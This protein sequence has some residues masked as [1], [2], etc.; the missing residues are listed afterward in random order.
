MTGLEPLQLACTQLGCCRIPTTSAAAHLGVPQVRLVVQPCPCL[1]TVPSSLQKQRV[2]GIAQAGLVGVTH[3]WL[4]P[5]VRLLLRAERTCSLGPSP[6]AVT[7]KQPPSNRS[8]LRV[9]LE[10]CIVLIEADPEFSEKAAQWGHSSVVFRCKKEKGKIGKRI[11][12]L[13]APESNFSSYKSTAHSRQ[14]VVLPLSISCSG[15]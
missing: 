7:S 10:E 4:A 15:P 2:V 3:C 14:A 13:W 9:A 1:K 5:W 12:S 6:E 8:R 11:C